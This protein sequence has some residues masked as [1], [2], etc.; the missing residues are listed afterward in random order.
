MSDSSSKKALYSMGIVCLALV[1]LS[2]G[3]LPAGAASPA[4]V[5]QQAEDSLQQG[6]PLQAYDK[7]QDA[8][9]MIWDR[10]GLRVKN[11]ALVQQKAT[12]Y[13]LSIPRANNVF[14]KQGKD[15]APIYIYM[16]LL[17]YRTSPLAGG[18]YKFGVSVDLDI[19]SPQGK[20]LL[21][22]Q[23]FARQE[24]VSRRRN[25]EFFL[26]LTITLGNAPTGKFILRP[27]VHDLGG[28]GQASMDIPIEIK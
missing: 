13:G 22:K 4:Q 26:N 27:T 3:S 18:K 21:S 5:M 19:L 10:L 15:L 11:V 16:E 25:R 7:A 14:V 23:G 17:G 28:A 20:V 8:L 2:A 6:H 12:G 24:M 9:Q 1:L